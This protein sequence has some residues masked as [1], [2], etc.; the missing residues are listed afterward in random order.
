MFTVPA[1][2]P[3]QNS[4]ISDRTL[5]MDTAIARQKKAYQRYPYPE[6]SQRIAQ[7]TALKKALLSHQTLL[8]DALNQ[9]Y[10][11]RP[12]HDTIIAD[13]LPCILNINYTLKRLKK[14][15]KPQRRNTGLL[16]MPANI[17]VH[18]QPLGV[19]GIMVP[20][21]FPI[22]LAIH[23]LTTALAAGN[24][25]MIKMSEF[26]PATNHLIQ[27]I[28]STIFDDKTVKIIEGDAVV[29]KYF[30]S[31]NFDHLLF[32]GSTAV[33]KHVMHAAA[34]NLT[35]V[36][37]ELGGKSPVIIANDIPITTAV[38]RLIYGKC[39]NAGQI[40]VAPDYIF[41]P[42][43]KVNEF[44][45]EY[46]Q[47]FQTMYRVK[48][49]SDTAPVQIADYANIINTNQHKRLLSYID[50]AEEKGAM[51]IP[52]DG[53][54]INRANRQLATQLVLNPTDD[55][56]LMQ[57]EIFG[58]I[59]PIMPY[60]IV[61]EAVNYINSKPRP[62]AL[63]IMSFDEKLHHE[64]LKNTHSGGVSIN[65]TVFHFAADDAPVGGIGDSGMGQY[66]GIEGFKTFSNAK[67]VL[68]R[69]KFS[70]AR[71]VHPPYHSFIQKILLKIFM[72]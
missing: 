5:A 65:E 15:L 14:W 18:Y 46:Q 32:T 47:Q 29:A 54:A 8:V 53:I 41:C 67:T 43:D 23:P 2:M 19:V 31:L 72:R 55:M 7:L 68:K 17:S 21:N 26:T 45:L 52:A 25:V 59:L 48:N 58:P 44:V 63:Y 13:I 10:G 39:L 69:G 12:A 42:K 4:S 30:S 71:L 1:F 3:Q 49:N 20:W 57:E 6:L 66:H 37:L 60:Q 64:L 11:H 28:F 36:T 61:S 51:V 16:F 56:L 35:P 9:D 38:S 22:M 50:D 24:R 34:D 27:H 40:C 62:L 70:L 33:A